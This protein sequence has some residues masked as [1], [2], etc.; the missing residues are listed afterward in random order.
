MVSVSPATLGPGDSTPS[1]GIHGCL[2]SCA[3][4]C[5]PCPACQSPDT[6]TPGTLSVFIMYSP[7]GGIS[8]FWKKSSSFVV[9]WKEQATIANFCPHWSIVYRYFCF[10]QKALLA[11]I[12]PRHWLFVNNTFIPDV[13]HSLHAHS[14]LPCSPH[15]H[16]DRHAHSQKIHE[17]SKFYFTDVNFFFPIKSQTQ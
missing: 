12:S 14:K 9:F 16:T 5:T 3:H 15:S 8:S 2:S 10:D 4:T 6:Q 7:G 11:P 1:S 17:S 13:I